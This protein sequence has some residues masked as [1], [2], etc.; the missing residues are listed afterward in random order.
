[1]NLEAR[2]IMY[3][4]KTLT[5]FHWVLTM[6]KKIQSIDSIEANAYGASKDV[7]GKNEKFKSNNIIKQ[8]KSD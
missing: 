2:I 7:I 8:Y 4:L 1:M 6:I 5:R 3:L